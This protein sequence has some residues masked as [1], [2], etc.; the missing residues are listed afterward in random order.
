MSEIIEK[1]I[2]DNEQFIAKISKMITEQN[3]KLNEKLVVLKDIDVK[4]LNDLEKALAQAGLHNINYPAFLEFQEECLLKFAREKYLIYWIPIYQKGLLDSIGNVGDNIGKLG[5]YMGFKF[6][7]QTDPRNPFPEIIKEDIENYLP[8]GFETDLK[9]IDGLLTFPK[10]HKDKVK[11]KY[12]KFLSNIQETTATIKQKT[13]IDFLLD[14]GK[15][16]F[17][18]FD[19]GKYP[20]NILREL[21]SPSKIKMTK[22]VLI[23]NPD[24]STSLVDFTYQQKIIDNLPKTAHATLELK[25]GS[26]KTLVTLA[27]CRKLKGI[28]LILVDSDI[29]RSQ[30]NSDIKKWCPE[31]QQ[32]IIIET[33]D[34]I[35]NALKYKKNDLWKLIEKTEIFSLIAFDEG[36]RAFS[37]IWSVSLSL[38]SHGKLFMS[39]TAKHR[40]LEDE[41]K[42][43]IGFGYSY[44]T[45]WQSLMQA[46]K[47]EFAKIRINILVNEKEKLARFL[48]RVNVRRKTVQMVFAR[49]VTSREGIYTGHDLVR[50]SSKI[51]DKKVTF[52]HGKS[53]GNKL[54]LLREKIVQDKFV[55]TSLAHRTLSIKTLESLHIFNPLASE[56]IP[57]QQ[58]GRF[59]HAR[60]RGK[61]ADVYFTFEEIKKPEAQDWI[62]FC[63]AKGYT[64]EFPDGRPKFER[65]TSIIDDL[66]DS[67]IQE[68]IEQSIIGKER[69]EKPILV[70]TSGPIPKT[71]PG[72]V[73]GYFK[74]PIVKER[75]EQMKQQPKLPRKGKT[76]E[77]LGFLSIYSELSRDEVIEKTRTKK[78]SYSSVYEA[79]A[80]LVDWGFIIKDETKDP[81]V[82]RLDFDSLTKFIQEKKEQEILTRKRKEF[83]LTI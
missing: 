64:L 3:N 8:K 24:G 19:Y 69:K 54:E 11:T 17:Y 66:A 59:G 47:K 70:K 50:R 33:Y 60:T 80:N 42:R 31:I 29:A 68:Q 46:Q 77:I 21:D 7:V 22:N 10:T 56:N 38:K 6:D 51:L 63:L 49:W 37:D 16:G 1:I 14:M 61:V 9:I 45:D 58:I 26:G 12:G 79:I 57:I 15:H 39:A 20:K 83:G 13:F 23:K 67:L 30:W 71:Q 62:Y 73:D 75:I 55:V 65:K 4:N 44:A 35:N 78:T 5:Q 43:K 34:M 41:I 36:E 32:E 82:I 18:I 2:Q 25:T 27:W 53:K 81:F 52:I 48:D 72:D 40:N 28:K 74:N 76:L